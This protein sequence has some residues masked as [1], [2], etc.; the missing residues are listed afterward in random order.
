MQPKPL[1]G[2]RT[3]IGHFLHCTKF[4]EYYHHQE[5][6]LMLLPNHTQAS[7]NLWLSLLI[8]TF[9]S[10]IFNMVIDLIG[11]ISTISL[12]FFIFCSCSDNWFRYLLILC[13]CFQALSHWFLIVISIPDSSVGKESACNSGDPGS[14]P[15]LEKSARE[16]ISYPLQ[17]TWASIVAQLVK[18]L[19][20]MWETWVWS[21]GWEDP[22]DKGKATHSSIL[23]WRIP[24]TIV[25]RVAKSWTWL[26]DFQKQ[27]YI[28]T[29]AKL[30]YLGENFLFWRY[31]GNLLILDIYLKK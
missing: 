5:S 13:S 17:Y 7:G 6:S 15:E 12:L 10:L 22:L 30:H 21:L 18:N 25:H 1:S 27:S 16:G 31:S 9:R 2:Y 19:P 26:S 28:I 3:N 4:Y 24:W 29:I 23:A 14:I 11:L 8:G 20:A